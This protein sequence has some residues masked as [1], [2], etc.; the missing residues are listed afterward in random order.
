MMIVLKMTKRDRILLKT[1]IIVGCIVRVISKFEYGDKRER[2]RGNVVP[3]NTMANLHSNYNI[4]SKTILQR[5]A[6]LNPSN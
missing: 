5:R 6:L 2:E 3:T 1:P 4:T